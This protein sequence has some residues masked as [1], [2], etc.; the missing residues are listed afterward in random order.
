MLLEDI[1]TVKVPKEKPRN[2]VAKNSVHKGGAGVH[3]D[4]K[5]DYKRRPKHKDQ[6]FSE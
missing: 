6:L 1:K 5:K 2:W 3:K 4:K